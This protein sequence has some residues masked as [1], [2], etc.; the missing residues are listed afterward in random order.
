MGPAWPGPHNRKSTTVPC[1][2]AT[3]RQYMYLPNAT[4]PQ[5]PQ[6]DFA[7]CCCLS[8]CLVSSAARWPPAVYD[9]AYLNADTQ[10]TINKLVFVHWWVS[11]WGGGQGEGHARARLGVPVPR[12]GGGGIAAHGDMVRDVP[13]STLTPL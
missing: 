4:C 13:S 8:Y 9:Y 12:G 1:R 2:Y 3:R 7:G 5:A 11:N 6:L 10:Q